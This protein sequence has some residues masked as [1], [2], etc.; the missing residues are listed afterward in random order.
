MKKKNAIIE[1]IRPEIRQLT[2]YH[3][4]DPGDTIKLDAMENPYQ[5]EPALIE[6]WQE[7][8][9]CASLNRYPDPT[10]HALKQEL[11]KT[12]EIPPT[13]DLILGNGSD[14]LIQML[15]QAMHQPGQVLL[16]PEPSFVMY[17]LLAQAIGMEYVGVPLRKDDFS[18]D[19]PA[20]L[21]AITTYQPALIFIANPNN[22]TGNAFAVEDLETILEHAP[23]AVV[24]DEAYTPFAETS[25]MA[26]LEEYPNLLVMRTV[27]K[28]GLAGLRLGLLA[29]PQSV[30][31]H[32]EKIRLPYNINILTQ[33]SAVFALQHYA[34]FEEQT[35]CIC[36]DR[37][38][39]L[40]QLRAL[41]EVQ[42]WPSQT[43][44]ILLRVKNAPELFTGLREQGV[45]IKCLHGSHPFLDNCLR[46]TIGT[47]EE[48]KIF[49]KVFTSLLHNN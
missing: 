17:S 27:S 9:G 25:F 21:E 15:I 20:M 19:L 18:L 46:V 45:L 14:E 2:A 32:L 23:G 42:V 13:M 10:A 22:P 29:G 31:E 49:L 37:S 47:P 44:F 16:A 7:H 11:R 24:L 5:W 8:L 40:Q 41:E 28:L 4:P 43:N 12:M 1:R 26:R 3:V 34:L 33:R 48:N 35:K 38:T 36:A 39:V 6:K 30:L